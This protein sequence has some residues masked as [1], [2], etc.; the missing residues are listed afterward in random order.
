MSAFRFAFML[1]FRD[2]RLMNEARRR[3]PILGRWARP[4]KYAALVA[5]AGGLSAAMT[6][7]DGV[8][9]SA[10]VSWETGAIA[11]GLLA[12]LA[13]V[14]VL[15]D[16]VLLRWYF[17]RLAGAG[18]PVEVV[19]DEQGLAWTIAGASGRHDWSTMTRDVATPEHLFLFVSRME[20]FTLPRRGLEGGD[21]EA[22]VAFARAKMP[23]A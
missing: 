20:A 8:P 10:L 17:G 19:L 3:S 14:D 16:H 11:L 2:Y 15:F 6:L 1:E 13:F 21:W 7:S 23:R 18:K 5:L 12:F 9:L 22:V 4:L